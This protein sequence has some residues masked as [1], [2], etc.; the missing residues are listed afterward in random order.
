MDEVRIWSTVRTKT[1]IQD[2]MWAGSVISDESDLVSYW[3]FDEGNGRILND[4]A[5]HENHGVIQDAEWTEDS[6]PISEGG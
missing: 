2:N 5:Q 3:N 1:Q 6:A 4:S